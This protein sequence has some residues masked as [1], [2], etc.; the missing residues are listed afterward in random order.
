MWKEGFSRTNV[1]Y[2]RQ[3]MQEN[4]I[5]IACYKGELAG[6]V[7]VETTNIDNEMLG[8]FGM[9]TVDTAF[10]GKKIG[11]ALVHASEDWAKKEGCTKMKLEN[12]SP[13]D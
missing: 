4:R 3:K 9:L 13:K 6:V 12:S 2:I 7:E 10:R 5:M 8:K 11:E 1:G